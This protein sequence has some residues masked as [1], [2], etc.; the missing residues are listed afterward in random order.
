MKSL[1]ILLSLFFTLILASCDIKEGT[2]IYDI[3]FPR[4]DSPEAQPIPP[5][6]SLQTSSSNL[7]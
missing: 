4:A 1:L 5:V 2:I 3:E 7:A 6:V